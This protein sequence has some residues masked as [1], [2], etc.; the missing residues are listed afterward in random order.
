[1]V[2]VLELL[3]VKMQLRNTT[4]NAGEVVLN[5]SSPPY[6]SSVDDD[7]DACSFSFH[8]P[9]VLNRANTRTSAQCLS[10][11]RSRGAFSCRPNLLT[12]PISSGCHDVVLARGDPVMLASILKRLAS[13]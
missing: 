8:V 7:D 4:I 10:E 1:M 3:D 5:R 11:W 13:N 12:M 6:T 9:L 2:S